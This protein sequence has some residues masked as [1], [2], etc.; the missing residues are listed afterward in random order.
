MARTSNLPP[1][2]F[3]QKDPLGGI[4]NVALPYQVPAFVASSL[5]SGA[6]VLS[7]SVSHVVSGLDPL[8]SVASGSGL[9]R[10]IDRVSDREDGVANYFEGAHYQ[11]TSDMIDWSI[12]PTLTTPAQD[13]PIVT[14]SGSGLA[15]GAYY[16]VVTVRSNIGGESNWVTGMTFASALLGPSVAAGECGSD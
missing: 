13:T 12:R 2:A 3:A 11:L 9:L 15:S 4:P 7:E 5:G 10:S 6:V 14:E 8:A 1:G 16:Y